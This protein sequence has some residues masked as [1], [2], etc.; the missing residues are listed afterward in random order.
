MGHLATSG[1]LYMGCCGHR[2]VWGAQNRAFYRGSEGG[3][4]L[5]SSIQHRILHEWSFLTS[6]TENLGGLQG[7]PTCQ[8]CLDVLTETKSGVLVEEGVRR[9]PV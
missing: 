7:G 9:V 1:V 8:E 6:K 5:L 4:S 3:L 2:D